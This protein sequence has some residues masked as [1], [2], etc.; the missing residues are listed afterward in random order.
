MANREYDPKFLIPAGPRVL[1]LVRHQY[2]K[3]VTYLHSNPSTLMDAIAEDIRNITP[4]SLERF[5]QSSKSLL[6][7]WMLFSES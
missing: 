5:Y 3:P 7:F 4:I 2:E 1:R 6:N